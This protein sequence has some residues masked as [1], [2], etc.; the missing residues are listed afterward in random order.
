M[1]RIMQKY[2][3]YVILL[4]NILVIGWTLK[5]MFF[6]EGSDVIGLFVL[7]GIAFLVLFDAYAVFLISFFERMESKKLWVEILFYT[8]LLWPF[9]LFL[10]VW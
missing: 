6:D 5:V 2:R 3:K 9:I 7:F 10:P 1:Q 4:V 8:C